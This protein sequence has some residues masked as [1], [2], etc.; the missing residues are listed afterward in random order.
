MPWSLEGNPNPIVCRPALPMDTPDVIELTRRI[1]EGED[2]VPH[3]WAEGLQD[4]DG[5]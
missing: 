4:P 1:W 5:M 2:Y 3:V